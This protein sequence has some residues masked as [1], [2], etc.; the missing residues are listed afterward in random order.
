M[1]VSN[2]NPQQYGGYAYA[3]RLASAREADPNQGGAL[4]AQDPNATPV[5]PQEIVPASAP[6]SNNNLWGWAAAAAGTAIVATTVIMSNN[7]T[8]ALEKALE[9]AKGAAPAV[10]DGAK[11][12][13][14][15]VEKAGEKAGKE[16]AKKA[17]DAFEGFG[18]LPKLS[19]KNG[20]EKA[21][22]FA[23]K[24]EAKQ[25]REATDQLSEKVLAQQIEALKRAKLAGVVIPKSQH[26]VNALDAITSPLTRLPDGAKVESELYNRLLK[27]GV[28][29]LTAQETAQLANAQLVLTKSQPLPGGK[30]QFAYKL[31]HLDKHTHADK[32][33]FGYVRGGTEETA[34]SAR[35]LARAL[36]GEIEFLGEGETFKA[37]AIYKNKAGDETHIV[38]EKWVPTADDL[39]DGNAIVIHDGITYNTMTPELA[40]L[41]K[42]SR[43]AGET[44]VT[45]YPVTT[46]GG[47]KIPGVYVLGGESDYPP[48]THALS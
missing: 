10:V 1:M 16:V 43:R 41:I 44:S 38:G 32:A 6:K 7:K 46:N 11:N 18:D 33:I 35:N 29:S 42:K 26:N 37:G 21:L 27:K 23:A 5:Y 25:A 8:K 40:K 47:E 2:Y 3:P 34:E 22:K 15:D 20:D 19:G 31:L 24:L 36:D 48:I 14:G 12:L 28:G 45:R 30:V 39:K 17:K 13:A 9:E 4:V